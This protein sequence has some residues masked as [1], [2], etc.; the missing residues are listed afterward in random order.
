MQI[1]MRE[2]SKF[3]SFLRNRLYYRSIFIR[4]FLKCKLILIL[5]SFRIPTLHFILYFLFATPMKSLSG[6]QVAGGESGV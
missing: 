3:F 6:Q 2:N 4:T 1:W 5:L